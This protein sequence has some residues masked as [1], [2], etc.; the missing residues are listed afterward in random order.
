MK[1]V[2]VKQPLKPEDE[3]PTEVLASAIID[4]SQGMKKIRAGRL[5]DRAI[6]LERGAIVHSAASAALAAD[7]AALERHLGVTDTGPRRA[8]RGRIGTAN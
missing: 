4:I 7:R 5:T 8:G 6:I 3:I 2:I 1:K